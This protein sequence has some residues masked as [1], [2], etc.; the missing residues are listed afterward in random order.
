MAKLDDL[1]RLMVK[2]GASDLH[3]TTGAPPSLRIDGRIEK[4]EYRDL[5][6][7]ECKALIMEILSEEQRR[8]FSEHW[9][10]DCAYSVPDCGRFRCNIFFQRKGVGAVFRYIPEDI[11]S[12]EELNL[13]KAIGEIIT[14]HQGLILVTGPTGSGKSTTLAAMINELNATEKLHI[15][16]LEDPIE[17]VHQNKKSLVN[18][19][20]ISTNTKSFAS[21]LKASLREDPDIILVGEMRDPETIGLALKAAETGHLVFGTLHTMSAPK[22]IDR[23][24]DSFSQDEQPQIRSMLSESL[25]AVIAQALLPK[26]NGK[27]RVAAHEIMINN[28]AIANLIR[29][30]RIFQIK[31]TMQTARGEGMQ[32]MDDALTKLMQEGKISIEL[33]KSMMAK[34]LSTNTSSPGPS[35]SA[36]VPNLGNLGVPRAGGGVPS[37]APMTGGSSPYLKKPG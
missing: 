31:S 8:R 25:K 1:F 28:M 5:T 26:V 35:N 12:M 20:E 24:I 13:P 4:L 7:E 37:I 17:F 33:G 23:I 34:G 22:A 32:T 21:A 14:A 10:L 6:D 3:L 9:D 27:G 19:R 30:N 36:S 15:L 2:Q 16:T 11:K 29:E 18:Q